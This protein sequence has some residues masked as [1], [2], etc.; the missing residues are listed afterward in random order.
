LR[1]GPG[2]C[3]TQA[4]AANAAGLPARQTNDVMASRIG[5]CLNMWR[6]PNF[7]FYYG[8]AGEQEPRGA[9]VVPLPAKY[10]N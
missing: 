3:S 9:S 10:G 7:K 4:G 5:L 1:I 8:A 6:V 2:P